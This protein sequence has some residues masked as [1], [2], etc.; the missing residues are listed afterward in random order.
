MKSTILSNEPTAA[1][2]SK[3]SKS[4][5]LRHLNSFG[6]TDLDSLMRDYTEESMLIT[7]EQTYTGIGEIRGFFTEI[8]KHFPKGHSN[9]QLDKLV[10]NNELGFIVWHATTPTLEVPLATDTFVIENGKIYR[11]TFAGELKFL[12]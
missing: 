9:F 8:M 2:L 6:N 7:H 3:D 10:A 11:Q 4:V 5:L 1:A 12:N